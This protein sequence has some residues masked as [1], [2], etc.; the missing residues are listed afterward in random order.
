VGFSLFYLRSVS[1]KD[2]YTDKV[3]GRRIKGMS[4]ATIYRGAMA[5]VVLQC[6]MVAIMIWKPDIVL[7]GLGEV[8]VL[9]VE[10]VDLNITPMEEEDD[11]P[12]G[13][14]PSPNPLPSPPPAPTQ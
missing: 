10:N 3:T 4:T 7:M 2:D 14:S 12:L 8:K 9:D 13:F 6:V 5:F 1:S 11:A